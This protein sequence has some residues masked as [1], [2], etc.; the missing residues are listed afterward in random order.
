MKLQQLFEKMIPNPLG[1][2]CSSEIMNQ[3][4]DLETEF[5]NWGFSHL[6]SPQK[7]IEA[8]KMLKQLGTP[9]NVD[10]DHLIPLEPQVDSEH[11]QKLIQTG[12]S[13]LPWVYL[14]KNKMYINDGN[15]RVVAAKLAG[16]KQVKVQLVDVDK[17]YKLMEDDQ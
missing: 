7:F 6:P 9:Q 8:N 3:F 11:I 14:Y 10:I 15:H 12:S 4:D 2:S 1:Q 5:A 17:V 13:D 16:N